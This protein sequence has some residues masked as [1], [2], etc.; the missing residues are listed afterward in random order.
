MSAIESWQGDNHS[1]PRTKEIEVVARLAAVIKDAQLDCECRSDLND[2]LTRFTILER[3]RSAHEYLFG[4]RDQ[5]VKIEVMLSFLK[6]LDELELT[7][8]D[9]TVYVELALLFE[10][11][12][13]AA[14]VGANS[15]RQLFTAAS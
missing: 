15:M 12:E 5:R 3:N 7:E 9:R 6:D 10:D 2:T 11:I 1:A 4:A 13:N 8:P 14:K